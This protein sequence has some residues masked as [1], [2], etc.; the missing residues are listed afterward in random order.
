MTWPSDWRDLLSVLWNSDRVTWSSQRSLKFLETFPRTRTFSQNLSWQLS[1]PWNK[2]L[3]IFFL[4]P[5]S[6]WHDEW[7][8][9]WAF[10]ERKS[11]EAL[12]L[13][14]RESTLSRQYKARPVNPSFRSWIEL[15]LA[16][17]SIDFILP[18]VFLDFKNNTSRMYIYN[19]TKLSLLCLFAR[20]LAVHI[21]FVVPMSSPHTS[22]DDYIHSFIQSAQSTGQGTTRYIFQWLF[23]LLSAR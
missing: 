17:W 7:S 23:Q 15:E 10:S 11:F 4:Q 21:S 16:S 12:F 14:E 6:S 2:F 13:Q 18:P 5:N 3:E 20:F 19:I 9:I 22:C 8:E 1:F